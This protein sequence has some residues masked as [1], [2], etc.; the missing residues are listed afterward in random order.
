M[1]DKFLT[2]PQKTMKKIFIFLN[3]KFEKKFMPNRNDL[4]RLNPKDY[5][6]FPIRK[7]THDKYVSKLSKK[8]IQTINYYCH[9]L[10]KKLGYRL[11]RNYYL[12]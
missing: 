12:K 4:Y 7:N 1:F 9:K 8:H 2:K 5:K 3:L 10:I 6:W 11:I